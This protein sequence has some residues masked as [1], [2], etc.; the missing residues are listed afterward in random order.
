[1]VKGRLAPEQGALIMKALQAAADALREAGTGQDASREGAPGEAWERRTSC[2][3]ITETS[4][5]DP[6]G[7][8]TCP[9]KA[10]H[11]P[12]PSVAWLRGNPHCEAYTGS[13]QAA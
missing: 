6:A 4:R 12:E 13:A 5:R 1:V 2:K 7:V 9:A 3:S 8:K 10:G 11:Q